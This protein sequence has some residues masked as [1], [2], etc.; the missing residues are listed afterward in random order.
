MSPICAL[1]IGAAEAGFAEE[2]AP[3]GHAGEQG[4]AGLRVRGGFVDDLVLVYLLNVGRGW[5]ECW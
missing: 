2:A 4:D 1:R 3:G 5:V